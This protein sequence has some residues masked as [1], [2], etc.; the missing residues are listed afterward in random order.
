[1]CV[2]LCAS[3]FD[4]GSALLRATQNASLEQSLRL[5]AHVELRNKGR[6]KAGYAVTLI[7]LGDTLLRMLMGA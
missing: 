7:R 3:P 1:M 6:G 2:G 5:P 4:T